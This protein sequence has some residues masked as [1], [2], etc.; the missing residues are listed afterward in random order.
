MLFQG[1]EAVAKKQRPIGSLLCV[2]W[3]KHSYGVTGMALTGSRGESTFET[4]W[5][6]AAVEVKELVLSAKRRLNR[7]ET[8]M[9]GICNAH[10]LCDASQALI[11][12]FES[13]RSSD[14]LVVPSRSTLEASALCNSAVAASNR[15][16]HTCLPSNAIVVCIPG[17]F[18]P[19][20]KISRA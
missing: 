19:S 11:A 9:C 20:I 5:K 8:K 13:T 14:G 10:L 6:E 7:F 3:K 2:L 18:N 4:P 12:V 17:P 15:R 1:F 16:M